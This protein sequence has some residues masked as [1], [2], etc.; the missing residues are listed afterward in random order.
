MSE[1]YGRYRVLGR[2]AAIYLK[3]AGVEQAAAQQHTNV[4]RVHVIGW[5]ARCVVG[6]RGRAGGRRG[7]ARKSYGR[8]CVPGCALWYNSRTVR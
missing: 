8:E 5:E 4:A 3:A 2:Q 1:G 6:G 7:A